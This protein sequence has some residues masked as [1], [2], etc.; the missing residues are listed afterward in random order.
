MKADGPN[1]QQIEYWNE[2]AGPNWVAGKA[3]IDELIGPLG[4]VAIERAAPAPG[5]TVLDVGCGTG[6]T[7]L[8]LGRRVGA[9]G[10]VV[11]LDI[12]APMLERAREDARAAGL[13]QV[14]FANADAQT[15]TFDER[16]DLVYSR[17]GVMFF[18][19]PP[20][21]FRNLSGALAGRGRVVF[22]CWQGVDRN[23]WVREIVAAVAKHV[24]MPPPADPAA[25]GPFSFADGGRVREILRD[26]GLADVSLEPHEQPLVLGGGRGLDEAVEQLLRVGPASRLLADASDEARIAAAASVREV[27]EPNQGPNGV[28]LGSAC[29]I[30]SAGRGA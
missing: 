23:A 19:D 28:S 25:P 4:R 15:H 9:E 20:A 30:V 1:A 13:S 10:S 8:E 16:C 27:L 21:A 29:W 7:A 3:G 2:Q 12:S 22:V 14:R 6:Q 5:E 26:A 11:G 18:A 24:E 17:F